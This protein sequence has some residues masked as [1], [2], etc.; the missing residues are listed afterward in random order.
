MFGEVDI[1][2]EEGLESDGFGRFRFDGE[3]FDGRIS[4]DFSRRL[5]RVLPEDF[6]RLIVVGRGIGR[7]IGRVVVGK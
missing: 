2:R 7:F 5:R 6:R 1:V 4:E 3:D